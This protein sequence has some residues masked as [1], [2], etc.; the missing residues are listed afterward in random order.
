[1]A[2]NA[3]RHSQGGKVKNGNVTIQSTADVSPKAQIDS[4]TQIWHF[5]Q[6]QEGGVS[7]EPESTSH[8]VNQRTQVC[9]GIGVLI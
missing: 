3:F 8:A 2:I 7:I 9:F 4:D 1:M 6:S 5:V